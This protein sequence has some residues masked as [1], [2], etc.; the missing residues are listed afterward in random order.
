MNAIANRSSHDILKNF[1][2]LNT[3]PNAHFND[4]CNDCLIE[5]YAK[6][7]VLFEQG[8]EAKEFIYLI[9][10][11]VSL[12]AGEMEMETIVTGSEAARFAIAHHNP[13]KAKGVAKSKVRIVRIPTHMLETERLKE[14]GQTYMVDEVQDHGGDWM[15]TML[16]SPVFQRLPAANLQKVMM[17][18]EEIAFEAG[19]I[20][21]KQGDE[22][23]FYYIIKSGDCELIRQP[24]EGARPVKLA[25]LHSCEAF[26]EDALL[27]GNPRNVTVK[28]KGKGQMLRLS[29][30]NFIK[31][32]K[33]PVLQYVSFE[34]GQQKISEGANWLDV[35]SPDAYEEGCIDG[36]INIPF[37]SLR[38]KVADLRHD[39]LQVLVCENGRTSEA[40]AFLLLKFGFNALILKGGMEEFE[41][42]SVTKVS[43]V[44][45]APVPKPPSEE[46]SSD[47]SAEHKEALQQ[48]QNKIMELEKLCA[49]FNE[50]LNT[51][52]LERDKLQQQ[53]EQQSKL[54]VEL[55]DSSRIIA[56]EMVVQNSSNA[57][58]DAEI[59]EGL[60]AQRE[61][62]EI[63]T[64]EL[65]EKQQLLNQALQEASDSSETLNSAKVQLVELSQV[66]GE[67]EQHL[68]SHR[69]ELSELKAALQTASVNE[70]EVSRE[71][72]QQLSN[73]EQ[74]LTEL[75]ALNSS[76]ETAHKEEQEKS[77][78]LSRSNEQLRQEQQGEA[79]TFSKLKA[80]AESNHLVLESEFNVLK[81]QLDEKT[82]AL[83]K[84]NERVETQDQELSTLNAACNDKESELLEKRSDINSFVLRLNESEV[85]LKALTE[86]NVTL[87]AEVEIKDVI[88]A[89][90]TE[91]LA[92]VERDRDAF[93]EQLVNS[94]GGVSNA[95]VEKEVLQ[96]KLDLA[97][98]DKEQAHQQLSD[99]QN[100]LA[101]GE[102]GQEQLL[103]QLEVSRKELEALSLS[104][105][106]ERTQW[107]NDLSQVE[108]EVVS[109]KAELAEQLKQI[110]EANTQQTLSMDDE[111]KA[112]KG[113]LLTSK[114]SLADALA[115]NEL[116]EQKA[117]DSKMLLS[118]SEG[119]H[120]ALLDELD[121]T[122]SELVVTQQTVELKQAEIE[123]FEE[124]KI[125]VTMQLAETQK[126][127]EQSNAESESLQQRCNELSSD[128]EKLSSGQESESD[129]LQ[130]RL[131]EWEGK[132]Q[133]SD[134]Q[135]SSLRGEL[136]AAEANLSSMVNDAKNASAELNTLKQN[137]SVNADNLGASQQKIIELE[138]SLKQLKAEN[139]RV[140]STSNTDN[141]KVS[142]L[143]ELLL[144]AQNEAKCSLEK[145]EE[146][147]RLQAEAEK[148]KVAL[149][150]QMEVTVN[151]KRSLQTQV[152]NLER[153]VAKSSGDDSG[154]ARIQELEKQL[155]E[156][157]TT[158]LDL[159][160][161]IETSVVDID[162]E[163]NEVEKNELK[164]VQSELNL[165]REQTEKDI[166]AMQIKLENSEKMNMAL[167]KKIL[168][169]QTIA[170][171]EVIP[172]EPST[173]KK[174]GWWK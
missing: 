57:S 152:T 103:E 154:E 56:E 78:E 84:Q 145:A 150:E 140:E 46:P 89:D 111:L 68:A 128:F 44:Q 171:Q 95:L 23:D 102:D 124:S 67:K 121:K 112:V 28:M 59:N 17:Q 38:M 106:N 159:E 82:Q 115:S 9:S 11:M 162:E 163:P 13:R 120:K 139:E 2:P 51:G 14:V 88:L 3:L 126:E 122:R 6:G 137:G 10:G 123:R 83:E 16:Q 173:E 20:V 144:I 105:E 136:Q 161:K 15:S 48:A 156:A 7:T 64:A 164:A 127:L 71:L 125:D 167:K 130:K 65:E 53:V 100:K 63:I 114:A 104:S 134:E 60:S 43:S 70:A 138:A 49:Q 116:L 93:K 22:A 142:E 58:R 148:E 81:Q 108:A 92:I 80:N 35:R 19:A 99:L 76:L 101:S 42:E 157:S 77:A 4:I 94:E 174:K 72:R 172:E 25:E 170:N 117:L 61:R 85:E 118:S 33:E 47:N 141:K 143:A 69:A 36:S 91:T 75:N 37:F 166:Q 132:F 62:N 26:G 55:Q 30:A 168:S 66:V 147:M 73:N 45:T 146:L 1:I 87:E 96:V 155:D 34:E 151:E 131:T 153:S 32:V 97:V 18:M 158:L 169:M 31:L 79:D 107:V 54:V 21:V 135:V 8:D 113:E 90:S 27:S 52:E 41:R 5:E 86:Q 109:T 74:T 29:K 98:A 40:A 149:E 39:Q 12:Y 110:E 165:V 24:S 160:I 133:E 119:N 50:K 129:L